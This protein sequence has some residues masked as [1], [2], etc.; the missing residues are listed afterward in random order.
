M[1]DGLFI[2]QKRLASATA[3][4]EW[5]NKLVVAAVSCGLWRTRLVLMMQAMYSP[6]QSHAALAPCCNL[7]VSSL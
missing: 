1:C 2:S 4:H 5:F 7:A 3:M 6:A